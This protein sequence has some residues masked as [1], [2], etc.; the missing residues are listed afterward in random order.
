MLYRKKLSQKPRT[1]SDPTLQY[2]N[3]V[4]DCLRCRATFSYVIINSVAAGVGLSIAIAPGDVG[5]RGLSPPG[6]FCLQRW[7]WHNLDG[8][9]RRRWSFVFVVVVVVALTFSMAPSITLRPTCLVLSSTRLTIPFAV[10]LVHDVV[11][12]SA[13]DFDDISLVVYVIVAL[14]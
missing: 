9:G 1:N 8:W 7:G 3:I 14:S 13:P 6:Y 5:T 12:V 11:F 10:V 4:V 2:S